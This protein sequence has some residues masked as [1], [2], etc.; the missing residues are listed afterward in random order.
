M[1]TTT[2]KQLLTY[3]SI[4]SFKKC[5][6][7]Y[8]WE[9]ELGYRGKVDAKALRMGTAGHD[10]LEAFKHEGIDAAMDAIAFTYAMYIEVPQEEF[11]F[12]KKTVECLIAGY[13][14]RWKESPLKIIETEMGFQIPLVNP[15]TDSAS[16]LFELAGKID[17]IVELEDGRQ[18]V[19]EH[20]FLSDSIE[21]DSDLW[22]RMQIDQ[23][24]TMYVIAA[25]HLGYPVDTVLYDVIRKPTIKPTPVPVLDEMGMKIVLDE[26]GDRPMTS[27]GQYY[28]TG[29]KEKG[30]T[31]QVREM[32]P[33]EWGKKLLDDI[34]ERPDF[35][36]VRKEIP[37]LDSDIEDFHYELWDIQKTIRN[38]QLKNRW[39][40]T[41]D[42]NTCN[43]CCFLPLC[44]SRYNPSDPLPE[45]FK[46]LTD[47]HPE[48]KED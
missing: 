2:E 8:Q 5:R 30:L 11:L 33:D 9:Y 42:F 40:K 36:Y 25:R 34:A 22:P 6:K 31:L 12:E 17:G 44:L 3:S 48:L 10:A 19:Q 46:I 18:A 27:R 20:K 7:R 37:R 45:G 23:Q 13:D 28:Q 41:V 47:V 1:S 4:A 21:P 15:A 39:Y 32:T 35:Y 24:I 14:W 16:Q 43:Y 26:R 38:A 29:N